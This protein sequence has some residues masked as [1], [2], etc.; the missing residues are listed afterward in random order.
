MMFHMRR[1]SRIY[2]GLKDDSMDF[3]N[4]LFRPIPIIYYSRHGF[5]TTSCVRTELM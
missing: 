1:I 3:P 2:N 4:S 5:Q